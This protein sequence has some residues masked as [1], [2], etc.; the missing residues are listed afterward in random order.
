MDIFAHALW[1]VVGVSEVHRRRKLP[2]RTIVTS[3]ILAMLPDLVHTF[4]LMGWA[5]FG[6]GSMGKISAYAFALPGQEPELPPLVAALSH[7]LHCTFHSAIV[8]GALTMVFWMARGNIWLPLFGWWSHIVIDVF[9]HSADFYPSPVFYPLTR[10]G[11][12]GVAWNTP[13]FM[14]LNYSALTLYALF[15]IFSASQRSKHR[16]DGNSDVGIKRNSI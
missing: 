16:A 15:L 4:P 7:H 6:D 10:G 14:L 9:T 13:W 3:V 11:F 8:V 5:M 12:D 1:A 2:S